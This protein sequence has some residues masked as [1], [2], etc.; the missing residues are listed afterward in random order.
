MH[1]NVFAA[2]HAVHLRLSPEYLHHLRIGRHEGHSFIA[3]EYLDG[4]TLKYLIAAGTLDT[5][6]IVALGIEVADAL[7][8]LTVKA[9]FIGHQTRNIF[10]HQAGPRQDS[11][12]RPG[13]EY[14]F[15][16]SRQPDR[17]AA[18][19]ISG[20]CRRST[21]HSP[22]TALGTEAYMSPEQV[23]AKNLDGRTDLFS[24]GIVLY[25]WR[26]GGCL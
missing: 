22:G 8:A 24:F 13:E 1:W 20:L 11:G 14:G 16:K 6:R 12:L 2:K 5:E 21:S 10:R 23:R 25:G 26:P 18:D 9:S 4:V 15:G 19:A 7:D 17:S 3:M